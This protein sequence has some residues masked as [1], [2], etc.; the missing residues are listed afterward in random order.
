MPIARPTRH[1]HPPPPLFRSLPAWRAESAYSSQPA[2]SGRSEPPAEGDNRRERGALNR[3]LASGRR[4][5]AG[6]DYGAVKRSWRNVERKRWKV[7]QNARDFVIYQLYSI[8]NPQI[9]G[10]FADFATG[11]FLLTPMCQKWTLNA[12]PC[13]FRVSPSRVPSWQAPL[14]PLRGIPPRHAQA[15]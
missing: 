13:E 12:W 7:V 8:Q 6:E 10:V 2:A 5:A 4:S 15:S 1:P 11:H 3:K 9:I 14:P